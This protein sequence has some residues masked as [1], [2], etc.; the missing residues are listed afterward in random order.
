RNGRRDLAEALLTRGVSIN[1]RDLSGWTALHWAAYGGHRTTVSLL[2]AQGANV[3]SVTDRGQAA[4]DLARAGR[5]QDIGLLLEAVSPGRGTTEADWKNADQECQHQGWS[6]T[7][8]RSG[9][10]V[11][12]GPQI[13]FG[14]DAKRRQA[15]YEDCMRARGFP[16]RR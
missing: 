12:L 13:E 3:N 15:L 5:H 7:P 10:W 9:M 11:P 2:V 16:A 6:S 14:S 4:L 8:P 1:A